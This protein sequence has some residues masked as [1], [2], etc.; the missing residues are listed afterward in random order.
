MLDEV[1]WLGGEMLSDPIDVK[2]KSGQ[3]DRQYGLI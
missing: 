3:P 1:N 2:L